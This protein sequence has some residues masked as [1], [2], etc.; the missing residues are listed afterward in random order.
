MNIVL[1]SLD[2]INLKVSENFKPGNDVYS[3]RFEPSIE[4]EEGSNRIRV[5][6]KTFFEGKKTGTAFVSGVIAIYQV[7]SLDDILITEGKRKDFFLLISRLTYGSL[8]GILYKQLKENGQ[9]KGIELPINK[10]EL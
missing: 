2:E 9:F 5:I 3:F 6:I 7:D 1:K 8:R 4:K 10:V